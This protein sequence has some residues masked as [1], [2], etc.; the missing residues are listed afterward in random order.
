MYPISHTPC[1]CSSCAGARR[2][3]TRRSPCTGSSGAGARRRLPRRNPCSGSGC[4]GARRWQTRRSPCSGSSCAGARRS[5]I[6]RTPCTGAGGAG[7]R[8][9]PTR[10][11]PC[12]GSSCAGA[13]TCLVVWRRVCSW[14]WIR[15]GPSWSRLFPQVTSAAWPF[16][17]MLIQAL[18]PPT[19]PRRLQPAAVSH[20]PR[21]RPRWFAP[22]R[23]PPPPARSPLALVTTYKDTAPSPPHRPGAAG[24]GCFPLPEPPSPTR[25]SCLEPPSGRLGCCSFCRRSIALPTPSILRG[26][27]LWRGG[28]PPMRRGRDIQG[29]R[30]PIPTECADSWPAMP[31]SGNVTRVHQLVWPRWVCPWWHHLS[32]ARI[33]SSPGRQFGRHCRRF[34]RCSHRVPHDRNRRSLH[35]T[36]RVHLPCRRPC[37][38]PSDNA[39][40]SAGGTFMARVLFTFFLAMFWGVTQTVIPGGATALG[41]RPAAMAVA[42]GDGRILIMLPGEM[43][44]TL[45]SLMSFSLSIALSRRMSQR[46]TPRS[47][48]EVFK[49]LA[50]EKEG[51]P[52]MRKMAD[53]RVLR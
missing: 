46:R 29:R 44:A 18:V 3:P 14:S 31:R 47:M 19:L 20:G 40:L 12:S 4:T 8:R 10:R 26:S 27:V 16:P 52:E 33:A 39:A 1:T 6:L 34:P 28:G 25:P 37:P 35:P 23:C 9:R 50:F 22:S 17:L 53:G 41:L 7:A 21:P 32:L 38:Q 51:G 43:G 11:S 45:R 30:P 36:T 24:A 42:C 49:V 48:D 5:L 13:R 2:R 15:P